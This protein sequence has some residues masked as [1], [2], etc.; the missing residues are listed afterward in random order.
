LY[1]VLPAGD[2]VS[3]TAES[4]LSPYVNALLSLPSN[5][6]ESPIEPLAAAFFI[7]HVGIAPPSQE[8]TDTEPRRHLVVPPL[9]YSTFPDLPDAATRNAEAVFR[10][11][12]KMLH[13]VAG[14]DDLEE[15]LDFWPPIETKDDSDEE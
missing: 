3:G 8:T 14:K 15:E 9:N 7:E 4:I 10:R 11:A 2:D 5:G 13:T 6:H 12:V 1:L